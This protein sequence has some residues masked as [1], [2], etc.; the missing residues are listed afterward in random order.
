MGCGIKNSEYHD[1]SRS[2][3]LRTMSKGKIVMRIVTGTAWR[4]GQKSTA[5][6]EIVKVH[7]WTLSFNGLSF[8]VV[9][10]YFTIRKEGCCKQRPPLPPQ[11]K[12]ALKNINSQIYATLEQIKIGKRIV[13][14]TEHTNLLQKTN[15]A[16]MVFPTNSLISYE[17]RSHKKSR[18]KAWFLRN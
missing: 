2:Q 9:V 11:K 18:R 16:R 15:P 5:E 14:E 12:T 4:K 17:Q 7:F 10:Y 8:S 3:S 1:S 13:L 6:S